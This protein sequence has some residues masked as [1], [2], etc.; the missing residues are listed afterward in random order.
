MERLA[1]LLTFV[2]GLAFLALALGGVLRELLNRAALYLTL[3]E[4]SGA[5]VA[6]LCALCGGLAATLAASQTRVERS[7]AG[8]G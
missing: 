6:L 1:D 2:L 3:W 5:L 7:E 8:E 4:G